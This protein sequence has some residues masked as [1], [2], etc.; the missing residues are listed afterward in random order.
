MNTSKEDEMI[1]KFIVATI[2]SLVMAVSLA[3]IL[4]PAEVS[5]AIQSRA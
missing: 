4:S 3:T 1:S 2:L 5:E